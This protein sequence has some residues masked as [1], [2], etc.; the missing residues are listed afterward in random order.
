VTG[1]L[2]ILILALVVVAV[3]VGAF[4][5]VPRLLPGPSE[6]PSAAPSASGAASATAS[7]STA[8][9]AVP[10]LTPTPSPSSGLPAYTCG[11]PITGP[12]S[13][14]IAHTADVRVGTHAGYD[15][16]VFEYL[17]TGTPAYRIAAA[18]PPFTQD[19]SGLPMIVNG[20]NVLEIVLNGGTKVA[21]D[22]SSTY[23]GA[24]EF[25]PGY[26]QLVHLVERG[27]FEAVN[28]WYLGLNGGDCLRAYVL[29][30]PSR[31]VIDIQH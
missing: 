1:P 29:S 13:V 2:R 17:E 14:G 16:V 7:A 18:H 26:L 27:D 5:I 20:G 4:L 23:T 11:L 24:T 10:S 28:T 19:P 15:R 3:G 6:S 9:T 25:E 21:D 22:G 30:G 12:A 8:A 31:I